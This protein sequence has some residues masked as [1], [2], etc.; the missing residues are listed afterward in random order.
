MW[1]YCSLIS[2]KQVRLHTPK[3][4]LV[5]SLHVC[6]IGLYTQFK[7]FRNSRF[8]PSTPRS[9]S[10][11]ADKVSVTSANVTSRESCSRACSCSI[12]LTPIAQLPRPSPNFLVHRPTSSSIAQLPR[13][14]SS[15][16][17]T[18]MVNDN[19]IVGRFNKDTRPAFE[20]L[21]AGTEREIVRL[22]QIAIQTRTSIN[23][24]S[25]ISSLP[26][27]MLS[28]IF[29]LCCQPKYNAIRGVDSQ[30]TCPL[31]LSAVCKAWR[32]LAWSMSPLWSVIILIKPEPHALHLEEILASWIKRAGN[33]AL[34]ICYEAQ[35]T[36]LLE[37]LTQE[38]SKWMNVSISLASESLS[39][40]KNCKCFPLLQHLSIH[41]RA[42][43][44]RPDFL[45]GFLHGFEYL[46]IFNAAS[47]PKITHLHVPKYLSCF[48]P[49][50]MWSQLRM[51]SADTIGHEGL[52]KI[53][54]FARSLEVFNANSIEA[55]F[56][57]KPLTVIH[58]N[59]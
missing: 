28:E 23:R 31:R 6:H 54:D 21:L 16:L 34:S 17:A 33:Q 4:V 51:F 36:S 45:G 8:R 32:D 19:L 29:V 56:S 58:S 30:E 7:E 41:V 50:L 42:H 26:S 35:S 25:I 12:V 20:S 49:N 2:T 10:R 22:E 14:S 1:C 24:Y 27:E 46:D 39:M 38:T 43:S 59:L 47:L 18:N 40:I 53:L 48:E 15:C 44:P 52:C 9:D 55:H 13:P 5:Q 57:Y 11:E 37:R 3:G